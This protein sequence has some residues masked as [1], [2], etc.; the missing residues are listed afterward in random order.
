MVDKRNE[1]KKNVMEWIK[2]WRSQHPEVPD[3]LLEGEN[4][5]R[6]YI[7]LQNEVI[8]QIGDFGENEISPNAQLVLYSGPEWQDV[9]AFCEASNGQYYM[10]SHTP[11]NVLWEGWFV[12][13]VRECIGE[14]DPKNSPITTRFLS[15]KDIN[16]VRIN[17][18]AMDD[19]TILCMDDFL[20]Y[21]VVL[22]GLEQGDICYVVGPKLTMQ[23]VGMLT[24]VP[25]A[26]NSLLED[27]RNLPSEFHVY[28][29]IVDI[30]GNLSFGPP[31]DINNARLFYSESGQI[32]AIALTD[33]LGLGTYAPN[34]YA[35]STTYSDLITILNTHEFSDISKAID[36]SVTF[37]DVNGTTIGR[38]YFNNNLD[39]M[40]QGSIPSSYA[41]S[42][43]TGDL[44]RAQNALGTAG[45]QA[46]LAKATIYLDVEGNAVGTSFD[47][48]LLDSYFSRGISADGAIPVV[49]GDLPANTMLKNWFTKD[50][51]N[52]MY[53]SQFANLSQT[54]RDI[55]YETQCNLMIETGEYRPFDDIDL[56]TRYLNNSGKSMSELD[57]FEHQMLDHIAQL[58][59]KTSR[60]FYKV[61]Q[62]VE[63]SVG[64]LQSPIGAAAGTVLLS[65][66]LAKSSVDMI[67]RSNDAFE[68]GRFNEGIGIALGWAADETIT[69]VGGAAL[70]AT[71]IAAASTVIAS[72]LAILVAAVAICAVCYHDAGVLGDIVNEFMVNFGMNYDAQLSANEKPS[73]LHF[74]NPRGD[75]YDMYYGTSARDII[76]GN[77]WNDKVYAA[78]GDD[79]IYT[80]GGTD[81]IHGGIGDD[82][83]VGGK[84]NDYLAGDAGDDKYVFYLGDGND[85]ICDIE[86]D[87]SKGR[88]D[89]IIFGE[90]INPNNLTVDRYGDHLYIKYS[91]SDSIV[92][93]D[94]YNWQNADGKAFVENIR[95]ADG[96]IWNSDKINKEAAIRYGS[97][98]N[99]YMEGY[100]NASGYD[101]NETLHGLNGDDKIVGN[102]GEDTLYGDAGND[103]IHGGDGDDVIIGGLGD[104]YLAGDNGNDEYRLYLGNGNDTIYDIEYNLTKGRDD[105]IKFGAG[106]S[107]DNI[108]VDR[109]GDHLYIE[110]SGMD[111]I[112]VKDAY[113]RQNADG[114]AFVEKLVFADGT[115]WDTD[116]INKEAAIR[117]GTDDN[118]LMQGYACA[119]GYDG[120]EELH[121]LG[122]NDKLLGNDGDDI[123][124]GD[125][126]NDEI[127]GGNGNDTIIGGVGNDYLLGEAGNDT[128]IMNIGSG[129][130]TIYDID[131]DISK[132]RN[133]SI[134]FG[135]GIKAENILVDRSGD[136]LYIK[137]SDTDTITVKDAYHRQNANGRAFVENLVFADGTVWNAEKINKEAAIRFGTEDNDYMVGYAS[138]SGYDDDEELHGLGGNDTL[139]GDDG[140]D[141]LYGDEGNDELRGGNGDDIIVGGTGND[142][143]NGDNGND[144]YIFNIGDGKDT[145]SDLENPNVNGRNDR[146]VFGEGINREDVTI[147]RNGSHLIISYSDTD[148]ITVSNAFHPSFSD[149]RAQIEKV[150]FNDSSIYSINYNT[151]S[152]ELIQ[153]AVT[154]DIEEDVIVDQTELL[155]D[156][157]EV[158]EDTET[159]AEVEEIADAEET[160]DVEE[161]TDDTDALAEVVESA[162]ESDETEDN[163]ESMASLANEFMSEQ[164]DEDSVISDESSIMNEIDNM[165]NLAIQDMS[166]DASGNVGESEDLFGDSSSSDY[167]QLWVVNE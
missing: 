72:P 76:L 54:D 59:E 140:E 143:L 41:F 27:G 25:L 79:I 17:Q 62:F 26:L 14:A 108:L 6:F 87:V 4:R 80:H 155:T 23:S 19:T 77:E 3:G 161:I 10:I 65:E 133:D 28:N 34:N 96:T 120:N 12:N 82:Y 63:E 126:G 142:T 46:E 163:I 138:A 104:D 158:P 21:N 99:D 111:S 49:V 136:N 164:E 102:S 125:A 106:I 67:K 134:K 149:G 18:Y 165:V 98:E 159:L 156:T 107:A 43:N 94:A 132:G 122:G 118:D 113:H 100:A 51:M 129:S 60:S 35:L 148:K 128:Y 145:I 20:S 9:Q 2:N 55:L 119:S 57:T 167:D 58:S 89:R 147:N 7:E 61:N 115:A 97:D 44:I 152:L 127:H 53:G 101:D 105:R 153:S 166:E 151:V 38:S 45:L 66:Y 139:R 86:H 37:L 13:A 150:E 130:D 1:I 73:I 131:Y 52:S 92:V 121:G 8:N 154:E 144:T 70:S 110:Y 56:Y 64:V 47:G 30:N 117:F 114:R 146:I 48:T 39:G 81:E 85:T 71:L 160:A 103:E 93:K 91:D 16:R 24:E 162:V 74:T 109:I 33:L 78:E 75:G 135:S 15:G 84:G 11:A 95:F 40:L 68:N 90:G 157:D 83:I 137:Y 22:A 5:K 123:L 32:N 36:S 112:V 88:N 116:K 31:V 50:A 124:Y 69:L 42:V 29:N 141:K